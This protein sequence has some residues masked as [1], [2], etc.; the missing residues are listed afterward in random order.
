MQRLRNALLL[1]AVQIKYCVEHNVW[2][3]W[4][5]AGRLSVL[6]LIRG[7]CNTSIAKISGGRKHGRTI[8]GGV[9]GLH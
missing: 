5:Y 6:W 1:Q 4:K 3:T 7:L 8:K 9:H 2:T